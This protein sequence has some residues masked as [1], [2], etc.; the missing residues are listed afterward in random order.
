MSVSAAVNSF[1]F[2]NTNM[3]ILVFFLAIFFI[4]RES[5]RPLHVLDNW[6]QLLLCCSSRDFSFENNL[7]LHPGGSIFPCFGVC[8]VGAK[9]PE[10]FRK[11]R[12]NNVYSFF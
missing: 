6:S 10:V 2:Y 3:F 11:C 1:H 5:W 12:T 8:C 7:D 9:G 4:S